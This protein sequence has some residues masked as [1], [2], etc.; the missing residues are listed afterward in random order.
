MTHITPGT[1]TRN[2]MSTAN[3]GKAMLPT[4]TGACGCAGVRL[5]KPFKGEGEGERRMTANV[6]REGQ[7][8]LV[9]RSRRAFNYMVCAC[10]THTYPQLG[11]GLPHNCL[12]FDSMGRRTIERRFKN[13]GL[14]REEDSNAYVSM[15]LSYAT[16][17]LASL[18]AYY[19]S[20]SRLS[21]YAKT[22]AERAGW[23]YVED[24]K[25]SFKLASINF[26]HPLFF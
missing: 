8:L 15:R 23:K 21:R 24:N 14:Q 10:A 20:I 6:S 1:R 18:S 7:R 4:Y 3:R 16:L 13:I 11:T 12:Q 2:G 17:R 5:C 25:P 19:F 22:A 26:P 9:E